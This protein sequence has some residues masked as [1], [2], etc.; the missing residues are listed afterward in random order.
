[1]KLADFVRTEKHLPNVPDAKSIKAD[2]LNMSQFQMRLLE[3]VEELTLYT[4]D[5]KAQNDELQKRLEAI[6]KQIRQQ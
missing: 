6:E 5:L 2:G 1:Q 3:K 4:I